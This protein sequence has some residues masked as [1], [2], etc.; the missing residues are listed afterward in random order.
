MPQPKK[1]FGRR[2]EV[3]GPLT[4]LERKRIEAIVKR[5]HKAAE[6]TLR[7]QDQW[8]G[9]P[10]EFPRELMQDFEF[11]M[12]DLIIHVCVTGTRGTDNASNVY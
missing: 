1:V 6:K 5:L 7:F 11:A 10:K 8:V 4:K 3:S 2:R 12:G 9:E